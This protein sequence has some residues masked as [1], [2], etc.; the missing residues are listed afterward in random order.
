MFYLISA[1]IYLNTSRTPE[2]LYCEQ[3]TN[4]AVIFASLTNF[5]YKYLL[6][7]GDASEMTMLKFLNQVILDFD[8]VF[9]LL[10]NH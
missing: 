7:G 8:K 3:Y 2:E 9:I 4:V 5:D 6:E 10:F 1:E